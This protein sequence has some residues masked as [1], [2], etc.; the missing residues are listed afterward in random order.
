[1]TSKKLIILSLATAAF[2]NIVQSRFSSLPSIPT[3]HGID[4]AVHLSGGAVATK[5]RRP[6][7]IRK[8]API[9]S[10]YYQKNASD[11]NKS[12]SSSS[13]EIVTNKDVLSPMAVLCMS[14]LAI[15]FGIQPILVRRYTPQTIVRS[16]VILV[17]EVVKF[18]IAGGIYLSGTGKERRRKDFEG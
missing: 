2:P 8:E 3:H 9:I 17:Q 5:T 14:L 4:A 6:V 12:V 11:S 1:M 18:I 16:S 10:T 15:Q 13:S 7:A